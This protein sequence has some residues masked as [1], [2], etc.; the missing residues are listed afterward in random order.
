MEDGGCDGDSS[1]KLA[2]STIL[3]AL[4]ATLKRWDLILK[5]VSSC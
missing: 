3:R 5:V 4:L 1:E 2:G